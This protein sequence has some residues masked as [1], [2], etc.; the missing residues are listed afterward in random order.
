MSQSKRYKESVQI[1]VRTP[2]ALASRTKRL[3]ARLEALEILLAAPGTKEEVRPSLA[4]LALRGLEREVIELEDE[5]KRKLANARTAN[6]AAKA[7]RKSDRRQ[8]ARDE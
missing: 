8:E 3:V 7:A 2:K 1:T 5:L 6:A 4:V